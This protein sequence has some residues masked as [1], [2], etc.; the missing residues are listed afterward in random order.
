M[1]FFAVFCG[2]WGALWALS[3]R[4]EPAWQTDW[5]VSW[6]VARSTKCLLAE[7]TRYLL[8][9]QN[10]RVH[11][12]VMDS[13]SWR[14]LSTSVGSVNLTLETALRDQCDLLL[15]EYELL[16]VLLESKAR[17]LRMGELR[18]L[19]LITQSGLTRVVDRLVEKQLLKRATVTDDKR[20]QAVALTPRGLALYL[21]GKEVC[22]QTLKTEL[23][24]RLSLS[25]LRALEQA[26]APLLGRE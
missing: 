19:L 12:A 21:R 15:S 25:E 23:K 18:D 26:I 22:E 9:Q 3:V 5:A 2:F 17:S 6:I 20:G 11:E 13:S 4:S 24:D 10:E 8:A 1:G 16:E 7:T 14:K